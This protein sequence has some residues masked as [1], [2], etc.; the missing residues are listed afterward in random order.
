[1]P[2]FFGLFFVFYD[3]PGTYI[4]SIKFM[5]YTFY[6][7]P[8]AEV[9]LHL[10]I[11]GRLSGT[12][13]CRAEIELGPALQQA[14]PLPIEP[15]PTITEPRRTVITV[16]IVDNDLRE[17]AETQIALNSV[18]VPRKISFLQNKRVYIGY[19]QSG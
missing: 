19:R 2:L 6:P 14:D 16:Y 11:A 10:F 7:S 5:Q 13:W 12:L 4:H 9:S 1:M 17:M 15:R 8:F 18:F 3:I